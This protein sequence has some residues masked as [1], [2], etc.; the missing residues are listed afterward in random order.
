MR[1]KK[2]IYTVSEVI[3]KLLIR[4]KRCRNDDGY[5]YYQVVM[6]IA[7]SRGED[8]M[9]CSLQDFLTNKHGRDYPCFATILRSRTKVQELNPELRS[10]KAVSD[11]RAA[12]EL[13]YKNF[14]RNYT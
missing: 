2:D 7:S 12:A 3:K 4:D 14:A 1:N 8:L 11:F 10:D 9:W 6:D 13:E 5:L